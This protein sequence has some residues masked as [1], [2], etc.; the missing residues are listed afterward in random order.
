ME[1]IFILSNEWFYNL[2]CQTKNGSSLVKFKR[3]LVI[4]NNFAQNYAKHKTLEEI[5]EINDYKFSCKR[6]PLTKK[7]M[8]HVQSPLL[9]HIIYDYMIFSFID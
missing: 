1:L 9:S 7:S 5:L 2:L 4:L 6:Q 8:W 3:N